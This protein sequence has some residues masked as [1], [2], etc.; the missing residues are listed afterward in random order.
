MDKNDSG[1][2]PIDDDWLAEIGLLRSGAGWQDMF[3]F[4]FHFTNCTLNCHRSDN[5]THLNCLTAHDAWHTYWHTECRPLS[6]MTRTQIY[7]LP[8]RHPLNPAYQ[9]ATSHH[10][11]LAVPRLNHCYQHWARYV[12]CWATASKECSPFTY[13][14]ASFCVSSTA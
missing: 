7:A 1:K 13:D 5:T 8:C 10:T 3:L 4:S 6:P 12:C 9:P 11:H 2:P 14:P